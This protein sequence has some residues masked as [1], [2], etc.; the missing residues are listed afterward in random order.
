[1]K[2]KSTFL[3]LIVLFLYGTSFGQLGIASVTYDLG[4]IETDKNF[5][6]YSG[7][8]FSDCPG[9]LTVTLPTDALILSTDVS[10]DMTSEA[11]SNISKQK[12]HFVVFPLAD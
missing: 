4:D 7:S 10:Y 1:M 2:T 9:L 5:N 6:Y 11:P 3:L 8:Q 12:S